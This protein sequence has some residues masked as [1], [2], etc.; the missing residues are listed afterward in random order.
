MAVTN[1]KLHLNDRALALEKRE[2][3][4]IPAA[5][6]D[7][8]HFLNLSRLPRT[9]HCFDN[10]NFQGVYPVASMVCL[11]AKPRKLNINT[12]TLKR[13]SDRM[14]LLQWQKS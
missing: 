4:R 10:S 3:S 5:V 11:D 2:R 1:A 8:H 13:W 14:I 6:S 12:F 9:I 7:L